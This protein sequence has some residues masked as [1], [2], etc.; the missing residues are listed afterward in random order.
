MRLVL[1]VE[2]RAHALAAQV[3]ADRVLIECGPDWIGAETIGGL[4]QWSGFIPD[5]EWTRWTD[6]GA[7]SK[8][9]RLRI[10]GRSVGPD[11]VAARKV[12]ELAQRMDADAPITALLLLR[13]LDNQPERCCGI[14][15]A[16]Q[17]SDG[18]LPFAVI[19]GSAN[20]EAEAWLL[21]GFVPRDSGE[22]ALLEQ[23]C[24]ELSLD[25]VREPDRLRGDRR[26][27]G[28]DGQ[29]DIKAVLARLTGD[30]RARE[31]RCLTETPLNLLAERGTTSGLC[32]F[33]FD[34]HDHLLP[35]FDPSPAAG[36]AALGE[37]RRSPL[38]PQY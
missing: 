28:K 13:D 11:Q 6:L 16:V 1:I 12:L 8:L 22:T 36:C 33:L 35:C 25:P 7:L 18:A 14:Q 29:R 9:H 15:A 31:E 37:V 30:D 21:N 38:L 2:D 34:L 19:I 26:R 3:L 27:P 20:P 32:A 5:T 10:H 4:R 17:E 23:L 24:R